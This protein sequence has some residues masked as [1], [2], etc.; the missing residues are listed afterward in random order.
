[1]V[2]EEISIN[3]K[4][5]RQFGSVLTSFAPGTTQGYARITRTAGTNPFLAYA[6][7]NDGAQPGERTG[8]GAFVPS[9]P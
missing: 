9:S 3:A 5:W 4:E 1:K 7:I 8:D 6:V 2:V